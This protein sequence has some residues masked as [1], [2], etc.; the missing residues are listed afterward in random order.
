MIRLV[1]VSG[2]SD[3]A[4]SC[5][6]DEL[7]STGT[8]VTTI[9]E[10]VGAPFTACGLLLDRRAS[11]QFSKR[12]LTTTS[13]AVARSFWP[14]IIRKRSGELFALSKMRQKYFNTST[15]KVPQEHLGSYTLR[16]PGQIAKID[17]KHISRFVIGSRRFV[18]SYCNI[19]LVMPR[20]QPSN[21]T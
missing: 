4:G 21:L 12:L 1:Q 17:I 18:D 3:I 16:H 11:D 19:Q 5:K 9:C 10:W 6:T 8:S 14:G 15:S 7:P 20:D 2:H 13:Y